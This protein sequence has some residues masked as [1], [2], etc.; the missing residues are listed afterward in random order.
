MA[1]EALHGSPTKSSS[2]LIMPFPVPASRKSRCHRSKYSIYVSKMPNVHDERG[3]EEEEEE[4]L[5]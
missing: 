1:L 2:D 5:Q 3:K 4:E